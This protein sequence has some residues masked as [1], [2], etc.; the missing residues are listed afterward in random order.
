[1]VQDKL[2]NVCQIKASGRSFAA[3]LGDGSVVAW[4]R[5]KLQSCG[6]DCRDVEDLLKG[7]RFIA[8]TDQAFAALRC[9]A[10][11]VTWGNKRCDIDP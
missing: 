3:V 9:D 11:V 8:A 2:V 4:D 5:R 6:G 10:R 7:V 1:M